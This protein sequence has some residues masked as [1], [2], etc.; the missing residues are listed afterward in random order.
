[1]A[2]ILIS[3]TYENLYFLSKKW[4][5]MKID[6]ALKDNSTRVSTLKSMRLS[7][8]I[9]WVRYVDSLIYEHVGSKSL[10]FVLR[11]FGRVKW[12]E[13]GSTQE[14]RCASESSEEK[15]DPHRRGDVPLSAPT[16]RLVKGIDVPRACEERVSTAMVG[17]DDIDIHVT[18][19]GAGILPMK[20]GEIGNHYFSVK[21][22]WVF[23]GIVG[24]PGQIPK[25]LWKS[26][27]IRVFRGVGSCGATIWRR[28][29]FPFTYFDIFCRDFTESVKN[30][31]WIFKSLP[32]KRGR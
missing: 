15:R 28:Q 32:T 30:L 29:D 16:W 9:L 8:V 25:N 21:R 23:A 1:M 2:T 6:W 19:Q 10:T 4:Q 20:K 24:N 11:H 17:R 31:R 12:R 5:F 14:G 7:Q 18:N 13:K 22:S 27:R 3:M 26:N